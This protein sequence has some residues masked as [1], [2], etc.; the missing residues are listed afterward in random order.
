MNTQQSRRLP[1]IK[2]RVLIIGRANAGKTSILQRVCET[3][4]SPSISRGGERITLDPSM[5]RGEHTIDDEIVFSN[6]AGY[7]F[8]DSRGVESGGTEELAILQE[9]IRRKCGQRRL[10]DKL[11][12]IWYCIPMDN[13]RP[14][15]DLRFFNDICPD[16]NDG[17]VS[18]VA[19]ERF[20]EHYLRPLGDHVRFVRLEQMHRQNRRCDDLI[21]TTAAALNEDAIALMLLTVQKSNLTLSVKT[22][23]NRIHSGAGFEVEGVESIVRKC[24]FA[25]PY[26]WVSVDSVLIYA[27][28]LTTL[29]VAQLLVV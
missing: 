14:E 10:R 21:E 18:K 15:L 5:D 27:T 8:H 26:I 28:C 1:E 6:H 25:F 17:I 7:I 22:A 12:A 16:Q 29:H 24:L 19:E 20:Q 23:L 3:T 2:F 9:F 11:H 4:E 13:H